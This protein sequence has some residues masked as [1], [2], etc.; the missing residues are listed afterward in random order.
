LSVFSLKND[1]IN[2]TER[3]FSNNLFFELYLRKVSYKSRQMVMLWC[4][5]YA[6]ILPKIIVCYVHSNRL[7]CFGIFFSFF[8]AQI[9]KH[10]W[11]FPNLFLFSCII[12]AIYR[13]YRFCIN[14]SSHLPLLAT[15][16]CF[17]LF[18]STASFGFD[19][20]LKV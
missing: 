15:K 4:L 13:V 7:I 1:K 16:G 11:N 20:K 3:G 18:I 8:H 9:V 6:V 12:S 5:N 10:S 2:N 17:S 19:F 14:S